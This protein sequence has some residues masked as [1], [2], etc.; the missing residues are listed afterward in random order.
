MLTYHLVSNASHG[1]ASLLPDGTFTYRPDAAFHG[2]DSFTY[3][4]TDAAAGEIATATVSLTVTGVNHA[5]EGADKTVTID[6]DNVVTLT[7]ADFGFTDQDGDA[8]YVLR[9]DSVRG[10]HLMYANSQVLV[11]GFVG[12]LSVANGRLKFVPDHNLNGDNT[13]GITFRVTD[14]PDSSN[15]D[16]TPNTITF[17]IGAV[18]DL[19]VQDESFSTDEDRALRAAWR[20]TTR[21]HQAATWLRSTTRLL[22]APPCSTP[23]ARSSIS[24]ADFHGT[25]SFRY[26]VT[27]PLA[28]E[29]CRDRVRDG[30]VGERRHGAR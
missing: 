18:D 8:F 13:A 10:G 9:V 20:R 25:D 6:E 21:R 26:R 27:D 19:F 12:F 29:N 22:T 5:P 17:N 7:D 4:A 16:P 3:A 1:A 23:T 11:P 2:Q 30:R 14:G 15:A 28:G 24:E